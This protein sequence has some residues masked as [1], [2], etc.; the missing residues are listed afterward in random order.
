MRTEQPSLATTSRAVKRSG[1]SPLVIL[2]VT[3]SDSHA[4][5][6]HLISYRL[7]MQGF[8][9]LNLGPCTTV[10][11]FIEAYRSRPDAIAVV[12]GSLNGHAYEDLKE[13]RDPRRRAALACPVILG[14]NLSVGSQKSEASLRRLYRL[15]VDHILEDSEALVPLLEQLVQAAA[16]PA[17]GAR[18]A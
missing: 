8:E 13:L 17:R 3:A 6:N 11:E 14:G 7:R 15:G 18:E 12:I 10:E 1:E 5:A 9:V 2:G 4:V 16:V